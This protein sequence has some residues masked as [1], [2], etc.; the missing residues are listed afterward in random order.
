MSVLNH[1]TTPFL[2]KTFRRRQKQ[3]SNTKNDLL[4][5]AFASNKTNR[6][7]VEPM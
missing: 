2:L 1:G 3:T 5:Y 6:A 4:Y 7:I